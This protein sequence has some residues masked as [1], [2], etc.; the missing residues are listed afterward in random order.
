MTFVPVGVR[1]C[2]YILEEGVVVQRED[3]NLTGWYEWH[4]SHI[5]V[6]PE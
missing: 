4:Q 6:E 2:I 1:P 5:G 3:Q